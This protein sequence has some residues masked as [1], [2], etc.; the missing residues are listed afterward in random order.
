[1]AVFSLPNKYGIGCFSKEAYDFV[2]WLVE[3]KQTYWQILPICPTSY[4]DSPYLEYV[5]YAFWY[6]NA[7]YDFELDLFMF[8]NLDD[9]L[10]Y[11]LYIVDYD[12]GVPYYSTGY[13]VAPCENKVIEIVGNFDNS[14]LPDDWENLNLV[15][16]VYDE[17]GDLIVKAVV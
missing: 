5:S 7:N 6:D 16:W 4:G 2:D 11:S 15:I 12:T 17:N 10:K 13:E 3:A 1:M 8:A 14:Q 9:G